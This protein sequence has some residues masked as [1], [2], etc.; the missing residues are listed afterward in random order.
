MLP[1]R[2]CASLADAFEEVRHVRALGLDQATDAEVF[3]HARE[4]GLTIATR[5]AD[6]QPLLALPRPAAAGG[7]AAVGQRRDGRDGGG[8]APAR[9]GD[10]GVPRG[11]GAR[12]VVRA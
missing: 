2:L 12:L 8:A 9:P 3:A 4:H 11:A 1:A 5:D 10:P 6:F 7:L